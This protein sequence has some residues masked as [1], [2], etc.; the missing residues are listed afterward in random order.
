LKKLKC[1]DCEKYLLKRG[2]WKNDCTESL[3]SNKLYKYAGINGLK[4]PSD[5][6]FDICVHCI[7]VFENI[8]YQT[9]DINF[10]SKRIIQQCEE[11]FVRIK[12]FNWFN[13]S[14]LC[15]NHRENILKKCILK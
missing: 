12:E 4:F 15:K 8:F 6:F 9:P 7:E 10:I 1:K 13:N 14:T 2:N 5:N 11:D 3:I